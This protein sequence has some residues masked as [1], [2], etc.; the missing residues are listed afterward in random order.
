MFTPTIENIEEIK[1]R[2]STLLTLVLTIRNNTM[3]RL[4][5]NN[6][7]IDKKHHD[8]L[9]DIYEEIH[10]FKDKFED[11]VVLECNHLR[12]KTFFD[13]HKYLVSLTRNLGRPQAGNHPNEF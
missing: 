10:G 8:L 3:D 12:R 1:H 11:P 9:H 2:M 5:N 4:R 7:L 13:L 6:N